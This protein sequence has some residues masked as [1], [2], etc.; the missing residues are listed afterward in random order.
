MNDVKI[1]KSKNKPIK[2]NFKIKPPVNKSYKKSRKKVNPSNKIKK[3]II[4]IKFNSNGFK[5]ERLT[6]EWIENRIKI[7]NNFT[8]KSLKKQTNQ[9]FETLVRYEDKTEKHVFNALS[10]YKPLPKNVHFIKESLYDDEVIKSIKGYKYLYLVRLDSDDM[11]HKT[12]IDELHNHTPDIYTKALISQKGFLYDSIKNRLVNYK[13][14]SPPF[15]T[16]IYNTNSYIKGKRYKIPKGHTD[17]IKLPHKIFNRK[18]FVVV[19][20]SNNTTTK[21]NGKNIIKTKKKIKE[22]LSNYK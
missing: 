11:Y 5:K 14:K 19:V 20:H 3:I 15:Y 12:Y 9:N 6:K 8:L 4:N 16:L 7:F 22:I 18:N 17:V 13:R 1:I 2:S 21:F 10:K